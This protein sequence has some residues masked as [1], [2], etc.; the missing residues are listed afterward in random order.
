[1]LHLL[2]SVVT[3]LDKRYLSSV[4]PPYASASPPAAAISAAA[5]GP[6]V[7]P[8][9]IVSPSPRAAAAT[10]PPQI[11]HNGRHESIASTSAPSMGGKTTDPAKMRTSIWPETCPTF[12]GPADSAT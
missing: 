1:M 9:G 10:A 5:N 3:R 8:R 4:G 11:A 7:E 6:A 12:P 2:Y